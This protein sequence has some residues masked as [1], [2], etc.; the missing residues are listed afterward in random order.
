MSV[1]RPIV[2]LDTNV[3]VSGLFHRPS[4]APRTILERFRDEAFT[5]A[6]S[7]TLLGELVDVITR[8]A[9]RRLISREALQGLLDNIR[10]DALIVRPLERPRVV[11][12][13]PDD[14][15][16]F[17]CALAADAACIVS[18]DK[19]VLAIKRFRDIHVLPPT[20]FLGW[21]ARR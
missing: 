10:E 2:V 5:V 9:L 7:P 21:L 12:S 11:A 6:I 13:D 16:L 14:D 4:S 17:A 18:G 8:P 3:F 20:E 15:R 1:S 19:S